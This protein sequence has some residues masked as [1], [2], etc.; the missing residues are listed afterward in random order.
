MPSRTIASKRLSFEYQPVHFSIEINHASFRG[1]DPRSVSTAVGRRRG[2]DDTVFLERIAC[3]PKRLRA[4][5]LRHTAYL[6]KPIV[7]LQISSDKLSIPEIAKVLPALAG[8]RLQPAFELKMAGPADALAV[9]MNVR[10]SAGAATGKFVA[11][12]A[13]PGQS[14]LGTVSVRHLNLAPIVNDARQRTDLTADARLNIRADSLSDLESMSGT[15]LVNAPRLVAS[16]YTRAERQGGARVH[17]RRIEGRG[18]AAAYGVAATAAGRI[19]LPKGSEPLSYDLRGRAR[20]LDLR[21]LPRQLGIPPAETNVD[22]E[23][24]VRG[25][26]PSGQS[27]ARVVDGDLRFDDSTVA[28]ARIARGSTAQFSIRGQDVATKPTQPS[29]AWI[30]SAWAAPSTC[31]LSRQISTK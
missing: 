19:T 30:S 6:T 12:V 17:G 26:E 11:D 13:M 1:T 10:S 8:V 27:Q 20:H 18:Q 3:G 22:T 5:A 2:R 14:L 24:R 25:I 16:G 9:E 29:P 15:V 4:G 23:Y 21:R 31:R 7:N 28:G